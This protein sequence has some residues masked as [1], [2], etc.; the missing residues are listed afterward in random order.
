ME[1]FKIRPKTQKQLLESSSTC[2]D[3]SSCTL[4]KPTATKKPLAYLSNQPYSNHHSTSVHSTLVLIFSNAFRLQ[5]YFCHKNL[6]S[7]LLISIKTFS[8]TTSACITYTTWDMR[9]VLIIHIFPTTFKFLFPPNR[10][11]SFNLYNTF[12]P[13]LVNMRRTFVV[14]KIYSQKL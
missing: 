13:V 10:Y 14:A 11:Q 6:N 9:K 12:R 7:S 2:Q 3:C 8:G 1:T 5:S 4:V